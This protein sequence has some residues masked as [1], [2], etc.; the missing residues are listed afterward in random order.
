MT[1][2][3]ASIRWRRLD[4]PGEDACRLSR[5]DSG[6]LLV[7]HARF[8]DSALDYVVRCDPAWRTISADVAGTAEGRDVGWAFARD[9]D[10]WT[11]NGERQDVP[12][13]ARDID[14]AFTPATN[15]MPVRVLQPGQKAGV[16]AA[17]FRWPEA[18]LELL[19]QVYVREDEA[20]VRYVSHTTG[21]RADL[22][23]NAD[24]F[25][26]DYPGLWRAEEQGDA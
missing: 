7:G 20:R 12:P 16:R 2:P 8:D 3:V 4:G 5:Q 22:T 21:F 10:G 23:V 18:R 15:L 14:L 19:E 11:M 6:W 24:G 26:T 1:Q 9:A 17:W 13:E 25:V